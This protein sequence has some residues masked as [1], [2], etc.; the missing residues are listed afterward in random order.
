MTDPSPQPEHHVKPEEQST[1]E[2]P[3]PA[4]N[5]GP[6]NDSGAPESQADSGP[7]AD[8]GT[9]GSPVDSGTPESQGDSGTPWSQGDPSAPGSPVGSGT[10]GWQGAP[11]APDGHWTVPG[12]APVPAE[13]PLIN[14]PHT[15]IDGWFRRIAAMF[16][17]SW[18]S[19][20]AIFAITQILPILATAG[21]G[22]V[23]AVA[24]LDL[25][26]FNG[27]RSVDGEFDDDRFL[28]TLL[29][30]LGVVL[31]VV[32]VLTV[33]RS[34]GYAAATYAAT[35]Q[36]GGIPV[37]LGEALA[38]GFRRC[39]G[40]FGWQVVVGL[41]MTAGLLACVLPGIYVYAATALVGPIFLFERGGSPIGRSFSIFNNNLGRILGR[42][43]LLLV[44][45]VA[46]GFA[47]NVFDQIG[48]AA[49]DATHDVSAIV[50]AGA[51]SAL[52]G[53]LLELPLAM[54]TFSGILLT[55]TEQRGYEGATTAT[56]I[57][58]LN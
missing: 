36:A 19:L 50:T 39:L 23:F 47:G 48:A 12:F 57:E 41:L 55:Y 6:H 7:Q 1:P 21:V 30:L 31:V 17:R 10:P 16:K 52:L 27:E 42:L 22:I 5:P 34:A 58:E 43:A 33:L 24:L 26:P 54:L 35:R 13:D 2:V 8:S 11:P 20:L 15:G 28:S 44:A 32:L 56:L 18:S 3:A 49:A 25:P 40:L 51:I 29:P 14:P 4:G 53:L 38:Y 37:R 46:V 9:L 45:T